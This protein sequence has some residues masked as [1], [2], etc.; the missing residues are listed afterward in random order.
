[1]T[2]EQKRVVMTKV[3]HKYQGAKLAPPSNPAF[4]S[5]DGNV[6]TIFV[7][8]TCTAKLGEYVPGNRIDIPVRCADCGTLCKVPAAFWNSVGAP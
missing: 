5:E 6:D 2:K 4:S 1:M 8:P 3:S 7:C